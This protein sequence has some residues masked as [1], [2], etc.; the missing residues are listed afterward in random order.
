MAVRDVPPEL[1]AELSRLPG[2]K[3]VQTTP[4]SLVELR[5]NYERPPFDKPEFRRAFS[6][7]VDRQAI[8]DTVLEGD[9]RIVTLAS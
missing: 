6:L 1:R 4:L 7:M 3:L 8:V 2:M 9:A 5:V